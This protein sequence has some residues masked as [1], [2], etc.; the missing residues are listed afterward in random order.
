MFSAHM[1]LSLRAWKSSGQTQFCPHEGLEMEMEEE[2]PVSLTNSWYSSVLPLHQC[3][4]CCANMRCCKH[5]IKHIG[6]AQKA[7]CAISPASLQ[8]GTSSRAGKSFSEQCKTKEKA[9][10]GLLECAEMGLEV[11]GSGLRV[12]QDQQQPCRPYPIPCPGPEILIWL[13]IDLLQW[14]SRHRSD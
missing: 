7:A 14:I 10:M 5:A 9:G 11:G 13:N 4:N 3:S 1:F 6:T 12:R 8:E 2:W